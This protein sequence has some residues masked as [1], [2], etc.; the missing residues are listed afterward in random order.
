M[1]TKDP[2]TSGAKGVYS[3]YGNIKYRNHGTAAANN[4]AI[5]KRPQMWVPGTGTLSDYEY[6]HVPIPGYSWDMHETKAQELGGHLVSIHS[7]EEIEF[8]ST[9]ANFGMQQ[10]DATPKVSGYHI[11]LNSGANRNDIFDKNS[12]TL[13]YSDGTPYDFKFS[14]FNDPLSYYDNDIGLRIEA[15]IMALHLLSGGQVVV[16][17]EKHN[18]LLLA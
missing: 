9:L 4:R 12:H 17:V 8:I 6:L 15:H 18:I 11:G 1:G 3:V 13:S 2:N 16:E 7:A 10:D 5:F 14:S